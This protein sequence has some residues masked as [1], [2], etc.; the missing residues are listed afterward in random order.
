MKLPA[1]LA[2]VAA[3]VSAIE[4]YQPRLFGI[5]LVIAAALLIANGLQPA[6]R[7]RHTGLRLRRRLSLAGVMPG[8]A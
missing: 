4:D 3:K 7:P 1:P 5:V 2:A 8:L 6:G